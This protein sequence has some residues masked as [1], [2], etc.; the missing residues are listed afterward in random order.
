MNWPEINEIERRAID[1][2]M[3]LKEAGGQLE[4]LFTLMRSAYNW[5]Y[6]GW[7]SDYNRLSDITINIMHATGA[8]VP[9][10]ESIINYLKKIDGLT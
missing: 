2:E 10:H 6:D 1:G 4:M 8:T 5:A 9:V 3:T 7:E